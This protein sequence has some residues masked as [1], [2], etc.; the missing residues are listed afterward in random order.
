M[1]TTQEPPAADARQS[2]FEV[3][4]GFLT[5]QKLDLDEPDHLWPGVTMI[6][7]DDDHS[8]VNTYVV[9]EPD[10]GDRSADLPALLRKSGAEPPRT[11]V[12]TPDSLSSGIR[13]LTRVLDGQVHRVVPLSE[14]LDG[15]IRPARICQ[16]LMVE[17]DPLD[18]GAA[19]KA[20]QDEA[21]R[22]KDTTENLLLSE[23]N[24]IDDQYAITPGKGRFE[25]L[26]HLYNGWALGT[27]PRLCIV[28]AP[29][30]HGKSKITH[31]LAKRLARHYAGSQL[32]AR[33]P[34]P[35]LISF[36]QYRRG[37]TS[38]GG[39]VLEA[40]GRF[41]NNLLTVEGFRYLIALRRILFI[42]DGYDEL[43]EASPDI[44]RD[45]IADFVRK[46]GPNSRILLT[47]RSNFY[48][49]S[50]D[51]VG[52]VGDPM[53]D[54][55]EVEV[56]DLLPFDLPQASRYI[57]IRLKDAAPQSRLMQRAQDMLRMDKNLE[58]L[59]SPIFLS[60]FV[61]L[62]A[63]EQFSIADVRKSG[64]LEFLI[65]RTFDRERIR[66][67][68]DFTD[69]QQRQYLEAIAFDLLTTGEMA[70]IR[71]DLEVFACEVADEEQLLRPDP[72]WRQLWNGLAS[73]HFLLPDDD[74]A[75][76]ARVTMRHQ[77]WREYFQGSALAARLAQGTTSARNHVPAFSDKEQA[78]AFAQLATRDLPEGVL[79]SAARFIS[80]P[81]RGRLLTML[82]GSGDKLLRNMLRME[83]LHG[84]SE[85]GEPLVLPQAL[86]AHLPGRDLSEIV[87]SSVRLDGSL[88]GANL[89]GCLF[90]KCDLEH[91]SLAGALL[92]RSVFNGC[93]ISPTVA[94]AE[95]ASVT[96]NGEQLFGPRL[97]A[98]Y[99]EDSTES[100]SSGSGSLDDGDSEF[101]A[102]AAEIV[103][104]R[105][106]RF[107]HNYGGEANAIFDKAISWTAF[108]GGVDPRQRDFV[109][110]RV[111]RALHAVQIVAEVPTGAGPR[112]A[113]RI[114]SDPALR[115]EIL[116]FVRTGEAGPSIERVISRLDR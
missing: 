58:V 61:N 116:A 14:F 32:G 57:A 99:R 86:T 12:I 85:S 35:V 2:L 96:I 110:R 113:V 20:R 17:D 71:A 4:Q 111:Y 37:S 33:P 49:T 89:T 7:A 76:R 16:E 67:R 62:I 43:V 73:H 27:S 105:L 26:K 80:E 53:L 15:F 10:G 44:A 70:Y 5:A 112:P 54:E 42:L 19:D 75:R 101:R 92:N 72:P 87:F 107:L 100:A 24:F 104:W 36:G 90:E 41:G 59:G 103:R 46:A 22:D 39:L 25:A 40:L 78:R 34:L 31:I 98:R 23:A 88:A 55:S 48:R 8:L 66:Q 79:R 108:M 83:L 74:N 18:S 91:A 64:S 77:V 6:R 29:A 50:S 30:G 56:V 21:R 97:R 63:E 45:N 102:W 38:F 69:P 94:E 115:A 95:V 68:H 82:S 13:D 3:L 81:A 114:T 109:V 51:V 84:E 47:A 60:E 1:T 52:Q 65:R 28:I 11:D 93:T 106:A 9:Y